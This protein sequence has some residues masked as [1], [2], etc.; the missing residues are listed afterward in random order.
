MKSLTFVS[1]RVAVAVAL[2]AFAGSAAA[3]VKGKH[4]S[5]GSIVVPENNGIEILVYNRGSKPASFEAAI[6]APNLAG[7]AYDVTDTVQPGQRIAVPIPCPRGG[8]PCAG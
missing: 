4:Y 8:G 5:P 7:F 6:E 3:G 1:I 2:L